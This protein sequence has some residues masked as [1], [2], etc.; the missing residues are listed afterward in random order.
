MKM[1]DI[2]QII[3]PE[4]D[5]QF[6]LRAC[7]VCESDNVAYVQQSCNGKWHGKCFDCGHS[8]EGAQVRHDAQRVWNE[9]ICHE[10]S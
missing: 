7:P 4:D 1:D 5:S 10:A 9:E 6:R 8:G 3:T 2:C